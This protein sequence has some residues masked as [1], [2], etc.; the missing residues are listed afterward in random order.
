MVA[1][2]VFHVFVGS[3]MSASLQTSG[4]MNSRAADPHVSNHTHG[5]V[6]VQGHIF[7]SLPQLTLYDAPAVHLRRH[8]HSSA[9][10][11][12][13]KSEGAQALDAEKDVFCYLRSCL[14][15]SDCE[16]PC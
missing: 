10:H 16:C 4:E 13:V 9:M 12:R 6:M 11:T 1:G 7:T 5:E 2:A 14:R 3:N 8:L 15:R